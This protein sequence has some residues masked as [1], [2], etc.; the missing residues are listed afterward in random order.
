MNG[1]VKA[2]GT[3]QRGKV[4]VMTA[5]VVLL[6]LLLVIVAC[7]TIYILCYFGERKT[8]AWYVQLTALAGYFFPFT[9]ILILPLDLASVSMINQT[10]YR[11]CLQRKGECHEPLLHIDTLCTISSQ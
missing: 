10:K 7:I 4:S 11:G 3:C 5:S 2:M 1:I 6:P 8:F 9:I